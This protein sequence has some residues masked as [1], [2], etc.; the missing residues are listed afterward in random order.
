[1]EFEFDPAK[2]PLNK[3]KHGI[4][5][6]EAQAIWKDGNLFELPTHGPDETR[7]V[8][9]GVIDGKHWMAAITYRDDRVRIISV[10]R[11]RELEI[12]NYEG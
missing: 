9:T 8:V 10:R 6:E 7:F 1:M 2:S 12:A 3:E 11:A 4:D 5:F